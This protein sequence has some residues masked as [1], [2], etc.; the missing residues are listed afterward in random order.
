MLNCH[1][2]GLADVVYKRLQWFK[3]YNDHHQ[4]VSLTCRYFGISRST[5]LRWAERFDPLHPEALEDHSRRPRKLR[6]PETSEKVVSIV[7]HLREQYP[8]IGKEAIADVLLR[9]YEEQVSSATVGRIIRR[10][11]LYYADSPSHESKRREYLQRLLPGDR[12]A[13]GF[14]FA[15]AIA[16]VFIALAVSMFGF[17]LSVPHVFAAE[18]STYTSNADPGNSADGSS[19]TG[20]SYQVDSVSMTWRESTGESDSYSE[21]SPDDTAGSGG[22]SGGS[23][24]GS[25]GTSGGGGDGGSHRG[26][27]TNVTGSVG[28]TG[29][30]QSET[31]SGGEV[32]SGEKPSHP[33]APRPRVPRRDPSIPVV[34]QPPLLPSL[35]D[36]PRFVL[37]PV[38]G[39]RFAPAED[40]FTVIDPV[41]APSRATL[42]ATS[43][44]CFAPETL[45][46][47]LVL[48]ALLFNLGFLLLAWAAYASVLERAKKASAALR[49]VPRRKK[50]TPRVQARTSARSRRWIAALLIFA[51]SSVPYIKVEAVATVPQNIIYNGQLKNAS[52]TAIT[53]NHMMRFSFWNSSD[54]VPADLNPDGTI[55]TSGPTYAGW[56]EFH[57]VKP[58]S[59]GYFTVKLGSGTSLPAF[60]AMSQTDLLNLHMQVEVKP[61]GSLDTAYEILDTN[62]N[63][64]NVDRSP[65]RSV[66]FALNADLLDQRDVGTGSGNIAILGPGG[67]FDPARIPGGTNSGSFVID[68]DGSSTSTALQFGSSVSRQLTY[69]GTNG[70]FNFSDDVRIDGNLTV[71]GFINGVDVTAL[72]PAQNTQL[73]VS[74]GAGLTVNVAGGGYRLNGST[75]SYNGATGVSVQNNATNYVFFGSGGLTVSTIGFPADESSIRVAQVVTSG[76]AIT[77]VADK[78]VLQSDDRERTYEQ[79]FNPAFEKVVFQGDA[80]TNVG[81]LSVSHDAINLKNF[82]LWTSTKTALQDY[83]V[84]LRVSLSSD[85]TQWVDNPLRI[86]YRTTSASALNNKMDISV[87]DTNGS[88]VTLSGSSTGLAST[89]WATT[90]LEFTGTPTWTPGQDFL[91]KFKLY[92]KDA[93]QMQLGGL[94]LQY[95]ELIGD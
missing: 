48:G 76:G 6:K 64:P 72:S 7:R 61:V 58:N 80:T 37:R 85:F 31:P 9:D 16:T 52:G 56:Q 20:S 79:F 59:S 15:P 53:T 26:H 67:V 95:R 49:R 13:G 86:A 3:Y 94:K 77:S 28:D 11:G 35:I 42:A 41:A 39:S 8:H 32:D 74:S 17:A 68:R 5:F 21:G 30:P 57:N 63:N 90:Q 36:L 50:K 19:I 44:D 89:S 47:R 69:D 43:A 23:S 92:A 66:P 71:T 12:T 81:Q 27:E 70:R 78:R 87:F 45:G 46:K 93:Y 40:F 62:P 25:G 34:T 91:I 54:A 14:S 84:I 73:R 55:V 22:D 88:P 51:L 38:F 24:G 60:T 65:I 4:N 29:A 75:T 82:Y 10:H 83:D 1:H 2:L 18:S 33:S